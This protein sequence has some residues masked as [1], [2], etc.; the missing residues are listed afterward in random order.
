MK[1]RIAAALLCAGLAVTALA[2]CS[3]GSDKSGGGAATTA[4]P[5]AGGETKAAEGDQAEETKAASSN[6]DFP[7]KN[8]KVIVP[9]EAKAEAFPLPH[10]PVSWQ[11]LQARTTST[12]TA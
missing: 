5:A 1:K 7:K 6:T 4:A 2:G 12:A 8:I 11:R 9:Y 10:P 3:G